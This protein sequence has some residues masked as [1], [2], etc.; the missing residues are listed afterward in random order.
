MIGDGELWR[1]LAEDVPHG[2]LTT[3]LLG[4]GERPGRVRFA[5]R[6]AMVVCAT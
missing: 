5:A 3:H 4:V 1:L 6:T 2:D